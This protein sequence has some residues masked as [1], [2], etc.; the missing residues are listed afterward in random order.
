[1]DALSFINHSGLDE[2]TIT[3][4]ILVSWS[5]LTVLRLRSTLQ[6]QRTRAD[7]LEYKYAQMEADLED[8]KSTLK[9][10]KATVQV[11][12]ESAANDAIN[13]RMLMRRTVSRRLGYVDNGKVAIRLPRLNSETVQIAVD[14]YGLLELLDELIEN[15]VVRN[16]QFAV[17][18][19][20][21]ATFG[22]VKDQQQTSDES[23][24]FSAC[25]SVQENVRY[26]MTTE[27]FQAIADVLQRND[28]LTSLEIFVTP[29]HRGN[30]WKQMPVDFETVKPILR[31]IRENSSLTL[32]KLQGMRFDAR[33]A[34][35][36]AAA[37]NDNET[38]DEVHLTDNQ[39][40]VSSLKA[41]VS[42]WETVEAPQVP[43]T[44][45]SPYFSG[46]PF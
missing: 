9:S 41:M 21:T 14:E 29:I 25:A 12:K 39:Q 27:L 42:N 19:V 44:P 30:L 18:P 13:R 26:E 36:L 23:Q 34:E 43:P 10:Q 40:D 7:F 17:F 24:M 33:A 38:L 31:E 5:I 11:L 28:R 1:M 2:F 46:R 16:V 6:A 35:A 15:K 37:I 22:S 45:M 3:I 32:L 8:L 4:L 20:R